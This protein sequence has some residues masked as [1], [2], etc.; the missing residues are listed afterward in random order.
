[1]CEYPFETEG[2][3]VDDMLVVR[4]RTPIVGDEPYISVAQ[5]EVLLAHA[6]AALMEAQRIDADLLQCVPHRLR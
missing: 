4:A 6:A 2:T 3:E 5:I 1:M